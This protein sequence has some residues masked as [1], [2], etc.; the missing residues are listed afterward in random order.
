[1][2]KYPKKKITFIINTS[3]QLSSR[4]QVVVNVMRDVPMRVVARLAAEKL[5]IAK[6]QEL[7]IVSEESGS[8]AGTITAE[9]ALYRYGAILS[10]FPETIV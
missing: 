10:I 2:D 4:K 7:K 1:M 8:V 3:F 9:S 6:D 5:E